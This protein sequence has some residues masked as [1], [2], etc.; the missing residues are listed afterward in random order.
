MLYVSAL[1][2]P[3]CLHT[4]YVDGLSAREF[5]IVAAATNCVSGDKGNHQQIFNWHMTEKC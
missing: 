1:N 2:Q 3:E 5:S 4:F